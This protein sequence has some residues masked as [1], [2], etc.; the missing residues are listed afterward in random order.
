MLAAQ[1]AEHELQKMLEEEWL[2]AVSL[3]NEG[4]ALHATQSAYALASPL[5]QATCRGSWASSMAHQI[6]R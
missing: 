5:K 3:L 6:R 1:L 4:L 2:E